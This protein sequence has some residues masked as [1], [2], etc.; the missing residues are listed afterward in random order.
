MLLINLTD[1]G[2]GQEN[3]MHCL[4]RRQKWQSFSFFNKKCILLL[5]WNTVLHLHLQCCNRMCNSNL[6]FIYLFEV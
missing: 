2:G 3:T 5:V 6:M 1:V 4:E